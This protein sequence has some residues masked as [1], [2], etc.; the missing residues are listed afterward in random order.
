MAGKI[1][2]ALLRP[3]YPSELRSAADWVHRTCLAALVWKPSRRTT[4]VCR[5]W[6]SKCWHPE[7]EVRPTLLPEEAAWV[8]FLVTV[9]SG[10]HPSTGTP[11]DARCNN[12]RPPGPP[13]AKRVRT[14][15]E[16]D[17]GRL[18]PAVLAIMEELT[19]IF[20]PLCPLPPVATTR[21]VP[22]P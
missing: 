11:V 9:G 14:D 2:F 3:H 20:P 10:A 4:R 22:Q 21:T 12:P 15:A 19:N 18:P 6:Q 5:P 7:S 17:P 16:S 1:R 8:D 13:P